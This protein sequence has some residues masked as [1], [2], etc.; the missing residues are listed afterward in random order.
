MAAVPRR[1]RQAALP[2][3]MVG[4]LRRRQPALCRGRV[5]R[6]P[7]RRNRGGTGLPA[8]AGTEDAAH[9]AAR[10]DHRFLFAHPVP[11]GRAVYA[12]AVAHRDHPGPTGRRPG[13]LPSSG[14]CP[15]F[16]DPVP[17]S[18]RHR[19]FPRN[20]RCAVAVRCGGARVPH[21]T[22]WRLSYLG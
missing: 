12:D 19:H 1:H 13:G 21:H 15:E 5:A 8:A 4:S 20:R 3:R 11:A 22:S 14:R 2:P 16:P 7:P 9:A 17:A 18:G 10:S 6:P